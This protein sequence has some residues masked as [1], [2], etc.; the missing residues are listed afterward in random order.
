VGAERIP[1]QSDPD[2]RER[3]NALLA[4]Y[5]AAL[6]ATRIDLMLA[7]RVVTDCTGA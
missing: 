1:L 7:L 5:I 2:Q 6:K 4:S 3:L